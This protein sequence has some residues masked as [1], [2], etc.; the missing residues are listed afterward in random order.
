MDSTQLQESTTASSGPAANP[1]TRV[2]NRI[3]SRH[4]MNMAV[5]M[6]VPLVFAGAL[7]SN[8]TLVDDPDIWWHLANARILTTTHQMIHFDPYSFTVTGHRWINWEWLSEQ[9]FWFSYQHFGLRGIYLLTWLLLCGNI[10]FVYWRGYWKARHAGAAFWAAAVGFVLMTVNS[11]PRMIIFAYLA[12]SAELAILEAA[13]RGRTRLLWLLPPLF[14]LWVNLH[15]TWLIGIVLLALYIACGL[16][17]LKLGVFEQRAFSAR[18]RGQLL[19]VLGVSLIALLGNPYGWRLLWN[20]FD[21]MLNQKLSV[22]T[23]AEWAPLNLAKADGKAVA[24][25]IM[26]MVVANCIRGHKWKVYE[27]AFVFLA[28]YAAIAHIRFAFLAAVLTTPLLAGD[29]QRAFSL[30]SDAKTIPVMNAVM[31]AGA[32]CFVLLMFPSETKLRA[33]LALQFPIQTIRS[34][35]PEWRTFDWDYVGGMMAFEAKP[36]FIDSRFDSFDHVGVM[37]EYRSIM[38][39]H[40]AFALMDKYRVDHALVKDYLPITDLLL[41]SPGW[42]EVKREKSYEGDYILFARTVDEP[43]VN[44]AHP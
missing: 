37:A 22:A 30:D 23:I 42:R 31:A 44:D 14:C 15:G 16:F 38:E 10:L 11:G 2:F 5:L 26:L 40:N 32:L 41:H 36:S 1:L 20:P 25:A 29:I 19:A 13:D 7:N 21:M 39:A 35:K 17:P 18:D 12:M 3:F 6:V 34:I 8:L 28:W 4:L 33:R 27:L 24:A 43:T 9:P